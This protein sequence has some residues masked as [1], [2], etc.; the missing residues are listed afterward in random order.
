VANLLKDGLGSNEIAEKIG[1]APSTITSYQKSIVPKTKS[2]NVVEL[3]K[4]LFTT[5]QALKQNVCWFE[6]STQDALRSFLNSR[7]AILSNYSMQ[8]SLSH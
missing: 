7:W 8:I 2:K 1:L 5:G 4:L 6:L 3:V